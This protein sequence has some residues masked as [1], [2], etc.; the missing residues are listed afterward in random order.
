M[1]LS[2]RVML[3]SLISAKCLAVMIIQHGIQPV[4]PVVIPL[5]TL[6]L[7][8]TIGGMNK[9]SLFSLFITGTDTGVGK[10]MVTAGLAHLLRS[11]GIDVGVMK[12][13]A[14]G[15]S[16]ATNR[17]QEDLVSDDTLCLIQAAG[18][19]DALEVVT[20]IALREPLSP[21]MAAVLEQREL[22]RESV[23]RT[24]RENFA[25]LSKRHDWVLVEG[26]G[27]IMVPLAHDF[28]VADL[29]RELELPILII[30]ADRLGV[31]NH[32][33]LTIEVARARG[34]KILGIVLNRVHAADDSCSTNAEA[35]RMVTDVPI[36][37]IL[38]FLEPCTIAGMAAGIAATPLVELRR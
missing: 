1:L 2:L 28:L 37:A 27:G 29:A 11:R 36:L 25:I 24:T 38:P 18:V 32:T 17:E 9:P 3:P 4:K 22:T 10:T 31:I 13:V 26:V 23:C 21:H 20:P 6:I 35:I 8:R 19:D 30:A 33:L 15:C 7:V 16:P 5:D 12:P 34:L 14:S